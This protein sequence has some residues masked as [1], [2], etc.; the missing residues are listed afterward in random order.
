MRAVAA[1]VEY[2]LGFIALAVFA[3]YALANGTPTEER[4][5]QAFK[6]GALVGSV[7]IAVMLLM[8]KP[9]NRLILGG[10]LWLVVGGAAAV[11]EQWWLLQGYQRLGEA[12]L[13]VA[14]LITGIVSLPTR[15]GFV[16]KVGTGST[17]RSASL[18]L[19]AAAVCAVAISVALRGDPKLAGVMPVIALAWL[20]RYLRGWVTGVA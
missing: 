1:I 7:E 4:W 8:R 10:N 11:G 20:N 9:A 16:G 12:S 5:I 18:A 6:L 15:A 13:L 14:M 2:L 17:V 19:L 3:S